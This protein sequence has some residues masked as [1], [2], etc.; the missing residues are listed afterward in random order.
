MRI[1][2]LASGM[3]TDSILRD[4]MR[5][6]R[7]PLDKLKQKKQVLEWQRDD[8]RTI[9]TAIFSFKNDI[10][11]VMKKPSTYRTRITTSTDEAKV[12][13]TASPSASRG[14][15]TIS[16]VTQLAS[17]AVK[18]SGKITADGSE[19]LDTGKGLYSQR[20]KFS[21]DITWEQGVV[22]SKN[23][24]A[25]EA[26][27]DFDLD[28]LNG[29]TLKDLENTSV[30]VNG[31]AYQIV[32]SGVP[33]ENQVL[34]Q[35]D[36]SLKFGTEIKKDSTIKVDYV[37][38]EQ[39]LEKKV[40]KDGMQVWDFGKGSLSE[41]T[42]KIDGTEYSLGNTNS[43]GMTELV[44]QDGSVIGKVNTEIG[45][46]FFE[47]KL[48]EDTEVEVAFKQNYTTFG[49]TAQTSKGESSEKFFVEGNQS[50]SNVIS[51][52]NNSDAGVSMF[53]DSETARLS[54]SR[55]ES[56]KFSDNDITTNGAFLNNLLNFDGGEYKAGKNA[57]FE[58]N[59]LETERTS[60]TF[61]MNGVTFTLKQT[62]DDPQTIAVN[63]DSSELLDNIVKFVHEYN[64]LVDQIQNKVSEKRYRSYKPLTD[65]QR[66]QLSDKQQD[67]W[68]E[69]ARSGLLRSDPM[70]N[71]ALSQMRI[72][73]YGVVEGDG[74]F[75]MLSNI[76]ITTSKDYLQGG[77]LEINENKLKEAIEKDPESVEK[78]F[79]G[80]S[81]IEGEKGIIFRLDKD[82]DAIRDNIGRKAGRTANSTNQTFTIGLEIV[83]VDNRIERFNA[84]LEQ[85][86]DRYWRQFTAMERAIQRANQQSAYIMQQFGGGMF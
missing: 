22:Q 27:T 47:P 46:I 26:G 9:N 74:A 6:E 60:N 69:K 16:K 42:V 40:S 52:V 10:L 48:E 35:T 19:K 78:L 4:L 38:E 28:L 14:A 75:K 71:S 84:R 15:F 29:V 63:N 66:E 85:I 58:V 61:T 53:Y 65:E 31:K 49:I 62:F 20:D 72:S 39:R 25:K 32:T 59:G 67:Q 82:I 50:L 23:V 43:E 54:M 12:S 83:D 73:T 41:L 13:A 11:S 8:Y 21:N 76:G 5:A 30:K 1:G 57:K 2:G 55:K 3:D 80:E 7:I 79:I 68:E 18:L 51:R 44:G 70:L 33:G 37:L 17:T 64:K 36:G 45:T 56:G 81:S 77:K 86:E 24:R 34:V